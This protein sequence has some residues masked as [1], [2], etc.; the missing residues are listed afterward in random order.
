MSIFVELYIVQ[1]TVAKPEYVGRPI[2]GRQQL[3]GM[4]GK[5]VVVAVA[6]RV[7]W[8]L[9]NQEEAIKLIALQSSSSRTRSIARLAGQPDDIKQLLLEWVYFL[10]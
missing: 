8:D 5:L 9:C 1:A 3:T 6:A 7:Q 2:D 4:A 10:V